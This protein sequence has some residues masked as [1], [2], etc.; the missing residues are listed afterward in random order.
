MKK[1]ILLT[2]EFPFKNGETFLEN[3]IDTLSDY[4]DKVI[5]YPIDICKNEIITRKINKK[6]IYIKPLNTISLRKRK[7]KFI[8]KSILLKKEYKE[9]KSFLKNVYCQYFMNIVNNNYNLIVEDLKKE[10]ITGDEVYLY[11]YWLYTTAEIVCKLKKYFISQGI[12]TKAFSRAHGF[13][14][15]EER[16][17]LNYLPRRE[18][19]LKNIDK[20]F[21]C[22]NDGKNHILELYPDYKE[23]IKTS[24]LGT[25][26]QKIDS[27]YKFSDELRIVSCSRV[28][29]V[30]RINIIIETLNLLEKSNIK[31]SWTHI[32]GGP[33]YKKMVKL[34]NKKLKSV[35][36]NMT[37]NVTNDKV[38]ELYNKSDYD[39]FINVSSSEGIP[40]SI[41]E[42][43]SFGI[44]VIA[45]D[46]GGT[47]EILVNNV[48]G[49]LVN[50]N[51]SPMELKSVLIDSK[52]IENDKYLK[53]RDNS[54]RIW[55]E[56]FNAKDNYKKFVK[57]IEKI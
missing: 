32:G 12:T 48:N 37:D 57:E 23:K 27:L 30:K 45:T 53:M 25:Y 36:I 29:K 40:V 15:Y 31:V 52:K 3:E 5:I 19:I 4:F 13:D 51:I 44:P 22:S 54:R 24:Y 38:Y 7:L 1:L 49:F 10:I 28:V 33:L 34:A 16:N 26:D 17:F 42:A 46:V 39:F 14:I 20:V 50:K 41:M 8:L 11:S 56:K 43:I 6:N 9:N 18:H 2:R 47:H 35:N 55:Q 21:P